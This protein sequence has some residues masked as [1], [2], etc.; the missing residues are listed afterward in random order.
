M[1]QLKSTNQALAE[2]RISFDEFDEIVNPPKQTVDFDN[3]IN[4]V[5]SRRQALKV[6]SIAGAS[7][8]MFAF[9]HAT[10]FSF[11]NAQAKEILL[12]F[13]EVSA[14]TLDT[15]TVPELLKVSY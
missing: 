1:S 7:A 9:M 2:K 14:N 8:G 13:K 3:I 12:D 6:V 4:A 5:I 15:I 10:P 11:N